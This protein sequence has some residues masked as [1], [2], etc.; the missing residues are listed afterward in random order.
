MVRSAIVRVGVVVTISLVA[1]GVLAGYAGAVSPTPPHIVAKPDNVMVNNKT[2]LT[3]TGFPAKTR[4]TIEECPAR[5][6]IVPQKPCVTNNKISVLTDGHGRF[7]RQFRVELCAGRRGPE[8]TSQICYVGDAPP[9]RRRHHHPARR[10]ENHGHIPLAVATDAR[11]CDGPGGPRRTNVIRAL[12]QQARTSPHPGGGKWARPSVLT[13]GAGIPRA[14]RPVCSLPELGAPANFFGAMPTT[15][16]R[17]CLDAG[18]AAGRRH[19]PFRA[20]SPERA[21]Q[22]TSPSPADAAGMIP[23][24]RDGT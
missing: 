17:E 11:R 14:R 16:C 12:G 7:V 15:P 1:T 8:P 20:P 9:R 18:A 2:T 23:D 10:A 13:G 5:N 6:W 4:L 21:R 22:R 24:V 19:E 3:G